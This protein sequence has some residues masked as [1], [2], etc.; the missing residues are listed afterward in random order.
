MEKKIGDVVRCTPKDTCESKIGIVIEIYMRLYR[1]YFGDPKWD[2]GFWSEAA[3]ELIC[4]K[5]QKN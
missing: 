3:T 4:G 2:R 5:R 1:V